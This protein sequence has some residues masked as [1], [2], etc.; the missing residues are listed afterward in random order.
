MKSKKASL[1]PLLIVLAVALVSV[2]FAVSCGGGATST[3][4]PQAGATQADE[5]AAAEATAAEAAAAEAAAEA[6]AA[7][8]AAAEQ[9]KSGGTITVAYFADH[10]TLDPAF[11]VAQLDNALLEQVYDKL[12]NINFDGSLKPALATSWEANEDRSAYT[13][14]LRKGVKF[15]SGKDFTAEDVLFTFNRLRDPEVSTTWLDHSK[16][17]KDIVALDDYT[18]RFDL[19]GPNGFFVDALTLYQTGILPTD[20]DF[21]RLA[22]EAFGTGPFI[23]EEYLPGERATMVRNPDYWEE[24]RPYLDEL[25]FVGI[26]E[27]AT[28]A[29]ALKSGDVDIVMRLEPQSV[30][31]LEAHPDTMVHSVHSGRITLF[32]DN[33]QAP[34]DNKLVRK[35]FQAA[36]NRELINQA[37]LLGLG[38]PARDHSIPPTDPNYAP[39]YAPPDYD[40]E[41][42]KSLLEEAGYPDGIDVVLNTGDVGPGMIELAVSF[43][44]SAAPAGIRVEIA[45][46]SGDA[47]WS[48]VYLVEP[49]VVGYWSGR[50]NAD[51]LLSTPYHSSSA[52]N[53]NKYSNPTID[54][55][56]ERGRAESPEEQKV[57]YAGVQRILI[58]DVPGLT[59]AFMPTLTGARNNVRGLGEPPHPLNRKIFKELWLED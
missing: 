36:T 23:L 11:S 10:G 51:Q 24:G 9:S 5:A 57:T 19:T 55:L 46:R 31:A 35:A 28:R 42:A 12:L 56:I 15:H 18:V 14:H 34:F 41:L 1:H 59:I 20:V 48:D 27:A 43:K 47:F 29:E 50:P 32:M 13:F 58:D 45:R 53:S 17:I 6:A 49:F 38:Q 39:Q 21:D 2:L 16:T 37:A 54:M 25:I 40:I 26:E 4:V 44:E 8:A 33:T 3:A 7:E 22:A 52:W 30:S